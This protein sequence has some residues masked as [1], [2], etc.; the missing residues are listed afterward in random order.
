MIAKAAFF[1]QLFGQRQRKFRQR[2]GPDDRN[3]RLAAF[4][5]VG[6]RVD[7]ILRDQSDPVA[8]IRDMLRSQPGPIAIDGK[9]RSLAILLWSR[10]GDHETLPDVGHG[11]AGTARIELLDTQRS[12][13][14]FS[15]ISPEPDEQQNAAQHPGQAAC[16]IGTAALA[17]RATG[18]REPRSDLCIIT[19]LAPLPA[20]SSGAGRLSAI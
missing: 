4:E 10:I 5:H 19:K 2:A 9:G 1:R 15:A 8:A 14:P 13:R 16:A 18:T 3:I 20:E 6:N 11:A 12:V 7:A 17:H